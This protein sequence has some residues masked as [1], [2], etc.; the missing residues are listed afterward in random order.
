[1]SN[2]KTSTKIFLCTA[3]LIIANIIIF[4]H[5]VMNHV[6][7]AWNIVPT[8]IIVMVIIINIKVMFWGGFKQENERARKEG[9][10]ED[11]YALNTSFPSSLTKVNILV[12][13]VFIILF[14]ILTILFGA[15]NNNYKYDQV[16]QGR[17][18]RVSDEG[19]TDIIISDDGVETKEN[20]KLVLDVEYK[21]NG[22]SYSVVVVDSFSSKRDIG[23]IDLCVQSNG[24][25]VCVK[26][27]LISYQIMFYAC[28]VLSVLTLLGFV[29]KLPNQYLVML[30]FIF[31]GIGIVCLFNSFHWSE[32]LLND[33]TV[34][35]ACFLTMGIMYYIQMVLMRIVFTIGRRK[36][37]NYMIS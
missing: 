25:F 28:I 29:F 36:D 12:K 24:D 4:A 37:Y 5:Q 21:V 19:S 20:R 32:W 33:F 18:V 23:F 3:I 7:T 27:N 8:I 34:L 13:I 16:V 1:V 14:V 9:Y 26:D 22:K 17:I 15:L 35:G 6:F 31:V 30:V 11:F 10:N 2:I